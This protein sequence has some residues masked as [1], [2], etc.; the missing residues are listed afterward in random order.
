MLISER[1]VLTV[2]EKSG[3]LQ[4]LVTAHLSAFYGQPWNCHGTCGFVI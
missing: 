4:K 3:D 1:I 2:L